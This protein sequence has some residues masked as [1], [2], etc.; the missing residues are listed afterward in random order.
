MKKILLLIPLF[1]SLSV[2]KI[3]AEDFPTLPDDDPI[4]PWSECPM[5][6]VNLTGLWYFVS[7]QTTTYMEISSDKSPELF[8][9]KMFKVTEHNKVITDMSS[10]VVSTGILNEEKSRLI[11]LTGSD[12]MTFGNRCYEKDNQITSQVFLD[13][14]SAVSTENTLKPIIQIQRYY[15]SKIK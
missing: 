11:W 6:Q 3:H 1:I 14:V 2:Y 12:I 4:F 13:V 15:P 10:T 8:L 9:I 5:N 7:G